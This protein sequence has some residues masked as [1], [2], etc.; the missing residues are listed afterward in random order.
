MTPLVHLQETIA[1]SPET[2][3][4]AWTAPGLMSRWLFKFTDNQIVISL[5]ELVV[6]GSIRYWK[7]PPKT[8]KL[9]ITGPI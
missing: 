8:K 5:Q 9:T 6:G 1:A 2:V 7:L 4:K 3:F